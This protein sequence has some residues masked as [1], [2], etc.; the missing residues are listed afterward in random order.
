MTQWVESPPHIDDARMRHIGDRHL[1]D[2]LDLTVPGLETVAKSG[3]DTDRALR[4]WRAYR[5]STAAPV[6]VADIGRW[7]RRRRSRPSAPPADDVLR[8][9]ESVGHVFGARAAQGGFLGAAD[10]LLEAE[11]DFLDSS[12]GRSRFY[13]FHYL[14]WMRPLLEAYALTGRP[15]YAARFGELVSQWYDARDQVIGGWPGL[16]VIWYSLGVRA[17]SG[18]FNQAISLLSAEPAFTDE[19][20]RRT[21]KSL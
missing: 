4:E 18:V 13:G 19:Q 20:W 1:L 16:D 12:L 3:D 2:S 11:V 10:H 14:Y 15:R 5:A 7:V 21:M 9:A 17:R 6:P 8:S